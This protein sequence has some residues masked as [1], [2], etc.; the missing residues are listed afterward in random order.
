ML[1]TGFLWILL[2][3]AVYGLIHSGL[4]SNTA[5]AKAVDLFGA[6]GKK[7]YRLFFVVIATLT[8]LSYISLIFL[9]PDGIVYQIPFPWV[10]LTALLQI[11]AL[12]GAALSIFASKVLPFLGL[13][14]IFL[15]ELAAPSETLITEGFY[16]H[17][18]H[19]VYSFSLLLIWLFPVMTWNYL[20]LF[21]GITLY[22]LIGSILEERKLVQ[23]FGK[24][25]ISYQQVTPA[26]IPRFFRKR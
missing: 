6:G 13:D 7:Y 17:M 20:G 14:V 16:K 23:T 5:K 11:I 10:L 15:P 21:I 19:P 24:A 22:L 25:Y 1:N 4:A 12:I 8:T 26:F 3:G 2:S 9:F 18:R